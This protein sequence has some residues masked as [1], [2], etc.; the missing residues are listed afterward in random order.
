MA[1]MLQSSGGAEVEMR[2]E[3]CS[4]TE[5]HGGGKD[6]SR[7]DKPMLEEGA[8]AI[9]PEKEPGTKSPSAANGFPRDP[10]VHVQCMLYNCMYMY[11]HM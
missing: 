8:V 1:T 6:S 10:K 3:G 9:S 2:E 11:I 4:P 5:L 7:G